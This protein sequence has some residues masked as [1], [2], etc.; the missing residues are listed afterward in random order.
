MASPTESEQYEFTLTD[1]FVRLSENS[2]KRLNGQAIQ[3]AVTKKRR[4]LERKRLN[5]RLD[6]MVISRYCCLDARLQ[7]KKS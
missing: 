7:H 2:E 1:N 3:N 5:Y 6:L 4:L